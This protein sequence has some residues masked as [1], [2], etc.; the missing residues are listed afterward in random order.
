MEKTI[1]LAVKG[2]VVKDGRMLILKRSA[3]DETG[4]GTWECPGGKLDFG[5]TLET[6]LAREIA[7]ETG[8]EVAVGK[9][10]FATTILTSPVRQVAILT[11]L[12][13]PETDA[14]VISEEH[15]D[16]SW[17]NKDEVKSLLTSG[18]VSDFEK[19]GVFEN[20]QIWESADYAAAS[21]K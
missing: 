11:Y 4:G 3:D 16:F 8:L 10:L 17:G 12:C 5:E 15:A 20:A 21:E 7:E 14:V 9:L 19:H 6:A 13:R 1:I 18:I 2:V